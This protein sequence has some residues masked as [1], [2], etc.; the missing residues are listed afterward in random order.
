MYVASQFYLLYRI[1]KIYQLVFNSLLLGE[2]LG[3]NNLVLIYILT[4][5][6]FHNCSVIVTIKFPSSDTGQFPQFLFQEIVSVHLFSIFTI[7]FHARLPISLKLFPQN[8]DG[9]D[10]PSFHHS[11]NNGGSCLDIPNYQIS[12]MHIF[13]KFFFKK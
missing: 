5:E 10:K 3:I 8:I 1:R 4:F 9:E 6:K 2:N 7:P 11:L 13:D 12:Y